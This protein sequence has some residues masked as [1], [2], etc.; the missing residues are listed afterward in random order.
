ML[1]RLAYLAVSNAFTVLP[2]LPMCD[3]EKEIEILALRHQIRVLQRQLGATRPR[4][5]PADRAFLAA[6]LAPLP[7]ATHPGHGS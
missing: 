1:V 4:F 2:L 6:L 3:R 5:D 7:R